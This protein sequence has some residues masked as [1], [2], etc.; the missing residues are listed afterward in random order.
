MKNNNVIEVKNLKKHFSTVGVRGIKSIKAVDGISF[1]VKKGEIFGFLGPNGAGKTTT[2]RC[3]MD[4]IRPTSGKILILDKDSHKNSVELKGKIGYLSGDVKLY[5]KWTGAEHIKF[6]ESIR[7]KSENVKSLIKK[8]NYD[9]TK[10]AK[11]LSS[12]NY[13]KLGLILAL[14]SDPEIL[15]MDEPTVG[16][17]P[18]LQ[19]TIYESLEDLKKKGTTIFMSSHNLPEVERVCDKAG[20]IK[21]GKLVGIETIEDLGKKRLRKV[22]IRFDDKYNKKDF[23][24]DGVEKVE[25]IP[26]GLILTVRGDIDDVVKK[27]ATYKLH[28][29][30]ISHATLE[31]VFLEFYGR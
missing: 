29:L 15:I 19:N 1:D 31:D 23:K 7:G 24:F 27:L 5:E 20:I 8:L 26:N 16:L 25:E 13:Q 28:D 2:I 4:F 17:D 14:M 11:H 10:K 3:L 22:E 30:E 21:E 9:P 6:V 12:G 18:L